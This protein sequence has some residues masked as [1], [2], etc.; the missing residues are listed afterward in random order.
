MKRANTFLAAE[1]GARPGPFA[2]FDDPRYAQLAFV[3]AKEYP[4]VAPSRTSAPLNEC[5]DGL[6]V[7]F[8]AR[9]AL[10]DER[11]AAS[12]VGKLRSAFE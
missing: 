11:L 4:S 2:L 5:D 10:P 8:A 6:P 3:H 7:K 9:T 1:G 12:P